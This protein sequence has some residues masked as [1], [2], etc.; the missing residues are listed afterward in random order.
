MFIQPRSHHIEAIEHAGKLY[1]TR[2]VIGSDEVDDVPMTT[3]ALLPPYLALELTAGL[4]G[5][6]TLTLLFELVSLF[7]HPSICECVFAGARR[8]VSDIL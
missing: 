3:T 7:C 5:Y 4:S 8:A 1:K 6:D 2:K